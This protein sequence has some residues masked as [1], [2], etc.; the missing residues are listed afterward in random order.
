MSWDRWA[1]VPEARPC[2][3]PFSYRR[4]TYDSGRCESAGMPHSRGGHE[5]V[6]LVDPT[7]RADSVFFA[8]FLRDRPL[9]A[10]LVFDCARFGC[11]A[12]TRFFRWWRQ[13]LSAC[14]IPLFLSLGDASRPVFAT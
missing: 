7:A 2:T 8:S 11:E 6:A 14:L 13:C 10:R 5:V 4:D 9:K 12:R 3:L 1:S